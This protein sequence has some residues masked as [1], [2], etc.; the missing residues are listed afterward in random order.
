MIPERI[1]LFSWEP[2]ESRTPRKDKTGWKKKPQDWTGVRL[3]RIRQST[4]HYLHNHSRT[5][6]TWPLVVVVVGVGTAAT[7]TSSGSTLSGGILR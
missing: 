3:L 2:H 1:F 7:T 5:T 6:T 4:S